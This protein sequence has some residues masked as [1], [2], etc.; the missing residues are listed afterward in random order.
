MGKKYIK[1]RVQFKVCD[2]DNNDISATY[3]INLGEGIPFRTL[4][5][6]KERNWNNG[7]MFYCNNNLPVRTQE[8][9]LRDSSYPSTNVTPPNFWGKDPPH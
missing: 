6:P 4:T 3:V 8:Q 2:G 9:I 7:P 5:W 1:P